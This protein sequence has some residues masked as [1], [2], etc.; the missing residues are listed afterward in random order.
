MG[1]DCRE[2][3]VQLLFGVPC[4]YCDTSA[5]WQLENRRARL[6]IS[7]GGMYFEGF[8][9]ALSTMLYHFTQPGMVHDLSLYIMVVCSVG[10][11]LVNANPLVRFDGYYLLADILQISN[12]EGRARHHARALLCWLLYGEPL[13]VAAPFEPRFQVGLALFG[14]AMQLYR[15]ALLLGLLIGVR[16]LLAPTRWAPVADLFAA[17]LVLSMVLP[18]WPRIMQEF[19]PITR[20]ERRRVALAR[21]GFLLAGVA[22]V[23]TTVPWPTTIPVTVV[24]TPERQQSVWVTVPGQ[25]RF[26]VAPGSWVQQG[27]CIAQLTNSEAVRDLALLKS[28]LATQATLA[29]QLSLG[30]L[31]DNDSQNAA[32]PAAVAALQ[33]LRDQVQQAEEYVRSLEILAPCDGVFLPGPSTAPPADA[34]TLA[35]WSGS[36]SDEE[37]RGAWLSEGTLL[38]TVAAKERWLAIGLLPQGSAARVSAGNKVAV[39]SVALAPT[40]RG[41]VVDVARMV[42]MELPPELATLTADPQTR[43]A[44]AH[45]LVKVSLGTAPV[46]FRS[47]QT[48]RAHIRVAAETL[49]AKL[50]RNLAATLRA[51]GFTPPTP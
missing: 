26:H 40:L 17:L 12:L 27:E 43:A 39:R 31:L 6:L 51:D 25:V 2:M 13:E 24:L 44:A 28:R 36:P 21:G 15:C 33:S 1:V 14:W 50:Q 18:M 37:N 47:G 8:L 32:F 29:E 3:G 42:E 19:A 7:A 5:A 11:L 23:V 38:G 41:E 30:S 46:G 4:L 20:S 45:Y 22:L 9:A 49:W 35:G 16:L 10:T 48:C 34:T